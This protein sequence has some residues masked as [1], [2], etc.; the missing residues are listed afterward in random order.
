MGAQVAI[1]V[2]AYKAHNTIKQ[3]FH[4][5]AMQ[6]QV[7]ECKIILVD[8]ADDKNYNYLYDNFPTLDLV[9]LRNEENIGPAQA[10]NKGLE[11]ALALY[12]EPD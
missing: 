11:K 7:E 4:S 3:L 5:I 12:P 10:R 8:D 1:I 2:P 6:T 9:I